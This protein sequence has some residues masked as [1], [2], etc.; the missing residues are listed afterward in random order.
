MASRREN[1]KEHDCYSAAYSRGS[2]ITLKNLSPDQK[3]FIISDYV[4]LINTRRRELR[5]S[6]S[7]FW[8]SH[9]ELFNQI[10]HL[11]FLLQLRGMCRV[12]NELF[13]WPFLEGLKYTNLFVFTDHKPNALFSYIRTLNRWAVQTQK[14]PPVYYAVKVSCISQY[15]QPKHLKMLHWLDFSFQKSDLKW[16]FNMFIW[17]Q[18]KNRRQFDCSN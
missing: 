12:L 15:S 7:I 6:L 11:W 18:L 2:A 10:F 8:K 5:F 17:N 16:T 1:K 13:K 14:Q 9:P 3:L 4:F